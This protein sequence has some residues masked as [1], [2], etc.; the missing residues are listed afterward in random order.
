MIG[1]HVHMGAGELL[2]VLVV[3]LLVFGPGR[4]PEMMGNLGKAMREFQ[5]G[6]REPPEIEKP[7]SYGGVYGVRERPPRL[8]RR[9]VPRRLACV[10][11]LPHVSQRGLD[12]FTEVVRR[13]LEGIVAKLRQAPYD[14][15]GGT[16]P[17]VKI[18]NCE[19][20]HALG[21]HEQFD[22]LRGKKRLACRA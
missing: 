19:Y 4:L 6:L 14:L 7:P 16:S 9:I 13:D 15:V 22:G 10:Q 1:S 3:V 21:R 18:K 17:W 8:L 12:L 11:Y 2:V 5:K 20:S